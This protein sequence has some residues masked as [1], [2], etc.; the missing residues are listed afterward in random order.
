MTVATDRLVPPGACDCH[1]HVFLDEGAYPFAAARRYTPPP[2]PI[3]DLARLHDGLG[4]DR[5][6]IVQPSVYGADNAATLEALRVLGPG[7]ARAVAVIDATTTDEQLAAFDAAG[8]RGVRV[9]LEVDG[10]RDARRATAWLREAAARV[11]P[12]GWHVQVFASLPLLGACSD[13]LG[14]LPVPLVFDHYA[15]AQAGLGSRQEGLAEVLELVGAGRAYVKLSAPYRCSGEPDYA[16]LADLTRLFIERNPD[17]MLWGSDWPHPQPGV[18]PTPQDVCPPHEVDL[19]HVLAQ[20]ARWTPDPAV[21]RGI[22][23]DNPAR[24]YGF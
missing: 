14:A 22:L 8:V 12:L 11:A 21:L 23:V 15:G 17:R 6:V 19:R 16:D 20:L 1:T 24:L 9:N 4:I 18:R 10:E 13:V 7:R 3:E 2:A 5:V